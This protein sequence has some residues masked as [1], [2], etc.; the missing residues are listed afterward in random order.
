MLADPVDSDDDPLLDA[1]GVVVV[2]LDDAVDDVVALLDVVD[3]PEVVWAATTASTATAAVPNTPK[4]VVSLLRKRSARSR[5]A[6]VMCRFGAGITG[7]PGVALSGSAFRC[8]PVAC[9]GA[10]AAPHE[11]R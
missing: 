2:P 7:P 9:R 4:D 1:D 5:S 10:A 6:T 8:E 3:V 11:D